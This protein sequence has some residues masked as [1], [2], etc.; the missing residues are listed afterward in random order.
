MD[1]CPSGLGAAFPAAREET[2]AASASGALNGSGPCVDRARD[3]QFGAADGAKFLE[4]YGPETRTRLSIDSDRLVVR[5]GGAGSR[6]R[7][8]SSK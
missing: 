6:F 4:L 8:I 5:F 1:L 2:P 7:P 3:I